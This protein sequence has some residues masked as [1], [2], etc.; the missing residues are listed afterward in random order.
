MTFSTK[1]IPKLE[2]LRD[3]ILSGTQIISLSGLTSI[4]SR[5]FI[6]AKLQAET[7]KT[8]VVVAESNKEL[9]NWECDLEFFNSK[10]ENSG[11]LTLPSME[12]DVYAGISPHAETLEKRALTLWQLSFLSP[13]FIVAS[14]KSLIIRT[15]SPN[16]MRELGV[17][18]ETRY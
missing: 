12:S 17:I 4:A 10:S 14:A 15:I 18:I 1:I 7:Q 6:I 9:E 11:I 8:F 3:E 16:K 5:A 13:A 2:Q